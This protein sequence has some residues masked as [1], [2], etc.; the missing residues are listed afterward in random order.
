MYFEGAVTAGTRTVRFFDPGLVPLA[1]PCQGC[2]FPP[3]T[4]ELP[5]IYPTAPPLPAQGLPSLSL[6]PIVFQTNF[7]RGNHWAR[8]TFTSCTLLFF[9]VSRFLILVDP[10]HPIPCGDTRAIVRR[11]VHQHLRLSRKL[12]FPQDLPATYSGSTP[13]PRSNCQITL[14]DPA[15]A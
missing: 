13:C 2:R 11:R 8:P 3:E 5:F 6:L 14:A 10:L 4:L 15:A 7:R 9:V 1:V 12:S